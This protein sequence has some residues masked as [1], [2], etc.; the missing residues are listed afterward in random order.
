MVSETFSQSG[1]TM[2]VTAAT[3]S[4][5]AGRGFDLN[6]DVD[7]LPASTSGAA[8]DFDDYGVAASLTLQDGT[9]R[10]QVFKGGSGSG[11]DAQALFVIRTGGV[12]DQ[13]FGGND[14]DVL[15]G[16]G[17]NDD[18]TGG[19][20]ADKFMF[21]AGEGGLDLILDFEVADEILVDVA[22]LSSNF[23]QAGAI[24]ASDFASGTSSASGFNGGGR[25]FFFETDTRI[26]WY[27][28]SGFAS[29]QM[30]LAQ[31][32]SGVDPSAADIKVF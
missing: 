14:D 22:N 17:G 29:D 2:T 20:G 15:W 21:K 28:A 9:S 12:D 25:E 31:I 4:F 1:G 26:L 11:V 32:S 18:L 8:R 5:S 13:L 6:V 23:G 7:G 3:S 10:T 30:A 19:Q 24:N 27:S 16:M